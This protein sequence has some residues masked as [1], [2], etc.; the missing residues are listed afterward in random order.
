MH[1]LAGP[2]P[3]QPQQFTSKCEMLW[4]TEVAPYATEIIYS[5]S[6]KGC[7]KGGSGAQLIQ[8]RQTG[9]QAAEAAALK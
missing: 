7:G 4:I 9:S 6:F 8:R 1:P 5:P 2:L 3:S